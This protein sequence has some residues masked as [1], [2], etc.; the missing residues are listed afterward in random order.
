M[1]CKS[2]S[3]KFFFDPK[4]DKLT[5]SITLHDKR[6]EAIIN[7]ASA[8]GT[9]HFTPDQF[10]SSA[11]HIGRES[12]IGCIIASVLVLSAGVIGIAYEVIIL[13]L[14]TIFIGFMV[15]IGGTI[16]LLGGRQPKRKTWDRFVKQWEDKMDGI[17]QLIKS[18]ALGNPPPDWKEEDIYDYGVSGIILCDREETVDW[19]VL[20]QFHTQTNSLILTADGYPSYLHGVAQ[21]LLK[22]KPD[23]NVYLLHGP[24][25][26]A[27]FLAGQ[28]SL[29]TSNMTDL[30]LDIA[31]IS[32]LSVLQKRFGS[33]DLKSLPLD[34]I[35]YRTL[36]AALSHCIANGVLLGS[37]LGANA[38]DSDTDT[39]FG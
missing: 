39:S 8:N 17:P 24:G 18:P 28:N 38:M 31:T 20:N 23:L 11:R 30:G 14:F 19:L 26:S 4:K 36:S 3:Y 5:S 35:P 16:S 21:T 13:L 34:A 29:P 32:G 33:K 22:N 25:T 6:F 7:H 27:S 12:K 37:I 10:F 9:Y 2:C 1:T 15:F